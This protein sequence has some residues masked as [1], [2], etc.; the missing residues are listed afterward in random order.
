MERMDGAVPFSDTADYD[1]AA[2]GLRRPRATVR[3][4][5]AAALLI[6][7][8]FVCIGWLVA[9]LVWLTALPWWP[10]PAGI[11]PLGLLALGIPLALWYAHAA[12]R[13]T[14][15][16]VRSFDI[17]LRYGVFVRVRR[18]IPRAR[19]Q[20]ADIRVGMLDRAVGLAR[21]KLYTAG[22]HADVGTIPGLTLE[23]AEALR[24]EF[25]SARNPDPA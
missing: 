23:E 22:A 9:D 24:A 3:A 20:H 11:G 10:L 14:Q 21:L 7:L 19:I 5:W 17:V 2:P 15:Y 18:C 8:C 1:P 4:I 13:A 16:A 25:L 12:Y 6:E